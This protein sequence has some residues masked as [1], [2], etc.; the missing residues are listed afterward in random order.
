MTRPIIHYGTPL[1]TPETLF[2]INPSVER[3][4]YIDAMDCALARASAVIRLIAYAGSDASGFD[5]R[6]ET[7]TNALWCV[8]G[9]IEQ[10]Q[11]ISDYAGNS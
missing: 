8:E 4:L 2:S 3:G 7:V 11:H 1:S 6:H 5:V 9:L 10:A